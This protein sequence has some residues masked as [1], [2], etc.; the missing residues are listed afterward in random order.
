MS[1]IKLNQYS[2]LNETAN[3]YEPIVKNGKIIGYLSSWAVNT[4]DIVESVFSKFLTN[5]NS[6]VLQ[7]EVFIDGGYEEKLGKVGVPLVS[8]TKNESTAGVELPH[9]RTDYITSEKVHCMTFDDIR[10]KY[11]K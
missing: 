8:I 9:I 1:I 7:K 6:K 4:P 5:L 11:N 2:L 10:K 3:R